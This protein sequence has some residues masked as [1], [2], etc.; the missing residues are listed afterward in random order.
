MGSIPRFG[1]LVGP[2]IAGTIGAVGISTLASAADG[3]EAGS[4]LPE[5]A[6]G[7]AFASPFISK[8]SGAAGGPDPL[9]YLRKGA[10]KA[11]SSLLTPTGMAGIWGATGFDKESAVDRATLGAEAAFSKELVKHSD[12]LTKPIQNQTMRSIVRGVLNAGMPLKWAMR[13]ARV[14]S[15]IGWAT[16]GAEGIYQLGKYAMEEQKPITTDGDRVAL[17][18]L[19]G[20]PFISKASGAAG[21]PDSLENILN[22]EKF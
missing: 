8:A 3:T 22:L 21:G 10:R 7:A 17:G 1:K 6:A 9:K 2:L 20:A 18:A 16:L 12:K 5:A 14:A 15:P 19:F 13:A 4:I 11:A